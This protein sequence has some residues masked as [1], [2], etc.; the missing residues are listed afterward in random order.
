MDIESLGPKTVEILYKE[1]LLM[2]VEDIYSA[3]YDKMIGKPGFGT[4][5]VDNLKKGVVESISRPYKTVLASLG[6]AEIGS[7]SADILYNAGFDSV[8]KLIEAA[9]KGD[10]SVFTSIKGMGDST[11]ETLVKAFTD[12]RLLE[13]IGKLSE[14]GLHLDSALDAKDEAVFENIFIDQVWVATGSFENF[15]PRS[16]ALSEIEKRGGRTASSVTSKTTHLLA[17]KGGGSKRKEAEKFGVA[18]VSEEEFLSLLKGD[19]I[20]LKAVETDSIEE[21][22]A[23]PEEQAPKQLSLFDDL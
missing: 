8:S 1:G 23:V 16:K 19:S 6:I 2:S 10:I 11:A 22:E 7:K 4:K 9:H 14:H 21:V 3:D 12:K 13:T 15:N 20:A 5:T 17:G 18:I